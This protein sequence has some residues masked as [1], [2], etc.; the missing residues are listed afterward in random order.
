MTTT[1][2]LTA[3][4]ILNQ[5]GSNSLMCLGVPRNSIYAIPETSE[6]L[7]GVQFKFTNCPKV[8]NGTVRV[9]LM[10]NDT[11]N[12]EILNVRGRKIAEFSDVYCDNLGRDG[13]IEGVTG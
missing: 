2:M 10:P 3:K 7:G 13:V 11:Y 8:R 4:T 6:H 1:A 5:I 9:I 12:V